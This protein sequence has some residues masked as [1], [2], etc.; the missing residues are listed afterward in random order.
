MFFVV[1]GMFQ[2]IMFLGWFEYI[3]RRINKQI[4]WP[5]KENLKYDVT[6]NIVILISGSMTLLL[7]IKSVFEY[8][9]SI[10]P[11]I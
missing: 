9:Y 11:T 1:M 10:F 8:I 3:W 6:S 2:Y 7:I 5:L 4:A